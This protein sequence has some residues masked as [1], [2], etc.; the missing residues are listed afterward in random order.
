LDK[1]EFLMIFTPMS[2]IFSKEFSELAT[3]MYYTI[4]KDLNYEEFSKAS[5]EVLRN[6]K[7]SNFPTPAE[8]LQAIKGNKE[9]NTQIEIETALSKFKLMLKKACSIKID[10]LKIS[11]TIQRLGGW[12]YC[13]S[14]DLKN[15][16]WLYK[17]FSEVYSN[18]LRLETPAEI[19]NVII[20]KRDI[21]NKN[22]GLFFPIS[23][24][25][26]EEKIKLLEENKGVINE[27]IHIRLKS[28][29]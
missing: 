13:L 14:Y 20:C 1:K 4:L 5:Q 23:S 16:E 18:V 7:Y 2:E 10:D 19:E 24:I 6:R 15:I 17:E 27:T 8:F 12:D 9:E 26:D 25:G 29:T 22:L 3:K 11:W 21:N 28:I